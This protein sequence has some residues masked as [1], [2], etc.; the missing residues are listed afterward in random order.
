MY[1]NIFFLWCTLCTIQSHGTK[2]HILVSKLR[3]GTSKTMQFVPVHLDLSLFCKS[4]CATCS[5]VCVILYHVTGSCKAGPNVRKPI[6]VTRCRFQVVASTLSLP[7]CR[8][9]FVASTKSSASLLG[10]TI[11]VLYLLIFSFRLPSPLFQVVASKW[12]LPS[13][14]FHVVACDEVVAFDLVCFM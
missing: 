7:L 1:R 2:L 13:C 6:R 9:H 14:R 8:F 3:S 5:P 10:S 12:L 11:D 4:H